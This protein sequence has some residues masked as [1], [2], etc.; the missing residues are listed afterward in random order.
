M[1][2]FELKI[3][4]SREIMALIVTAR[5]GESTVSTQSIVEIPN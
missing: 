2:G 5:K 1:R 3:C 4:I